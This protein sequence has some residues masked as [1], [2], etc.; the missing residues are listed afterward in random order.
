MT[1]QR[2]VGICPE[3]LYLTATN[4]RTFAASLSDCLG[5]QYTVQLILRIAGTH[6][7][8]PATM[9]PNMM[10]VVIQRVGGFE[11]SEDGSNGVDG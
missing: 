10:V 3:R 8:R 5:G 9:A 6:T 7:R 2:L 11:R 4:Q 1:L